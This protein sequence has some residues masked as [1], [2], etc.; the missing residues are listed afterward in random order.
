[1]PT[2]PQPA[3]EEIWRAALKAADPYDVTLAALPEPP[4]GGRL[5]VLG[6]GKAAAR[7]AKAAEARY[8]D[9]AAGLVVTPDGYGA[10][11]Q[12]LD[13]VEASH[14]TPD[15]RGLV[16]AARALDLA[17]R[18]GEGDLLL[19]LISGGA[20]AL[21]PAPV[22]GVSLAEKQ[23]LTR[24]LLASGAPIAAI[25][26]VRKHL[27]RLK[28]GR[29]ALAAWPARALTLAVSDVPGDD[30]AVIGSGPTVGD[31]TSL[32]EARAT[33]A[34][35][36]VDAPASVRAALGDPANE[37]P[38]PGDPRLGRSAFQL[39]LRPADMLAAAARDAERLGYRP[40]ILGDAL[41]GEAKDVA[42]E[43]AKLALSAP[44]GTALISGGELAVTG[45]NSGESGG[46]CREYLLAMVIALQGAPHIS[47]CALDSDGVDGK[48]AEA[49]ARI[50][51]STLA[52]AAALSLNADVHLARHAS[53][54]FFNALGDAIVT[55]PT[56]TN[57]ADLR[58][59]LIGRD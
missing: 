59:I 23:A 57:L 20:S 28:G 9:R 15:A 7:M 16:A 38:K 11:L 17:E 50:D 41:R 29:L 49:G 31:P 48:G 25:N 2:F 44:P 46:R 14:P 22:A 58:V 21:L 34:R 53:G 5:L 54:A 6:A 18:L 4:A 13:M 55:G 36:G 24:A 8:G 52:R 35:H 43:H 37:T 33:L 51:P 1:V 30:P 19:S 47:A 32:A 3:L 40:V 12:Y 39:I 42:A 56:R 10:P 45:A 27:S 26:G